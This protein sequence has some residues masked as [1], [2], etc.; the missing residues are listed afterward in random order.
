[1]KSQSLGTKFPRRRLR[2]GPSVT[3]LSPGLW[4]TN[5]F[6]SF[7]Q[8]ARV[9]QQTNIQQLVYQHSAGLDFQTSLEQQTQTSLVFLCLQWIFISLSIDQSLSPWPS[10]QIL[11]ADI[12]YVIAALLPGS[13]STGRVFSNV[14]LYMENLN[15][16]LLYKPILQMWHRRGST[17]HFF[18]KYNMPDIVLHISAAIEMHWQRTLRKTHHQRKKVLPSLVG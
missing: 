16:L 2:R 10:P 13:S 4:T 5:P 17:V 18:C 6:S 11:S 3:G 14:Q 8:W 9:A 7:C 1:M 15:V 12:A